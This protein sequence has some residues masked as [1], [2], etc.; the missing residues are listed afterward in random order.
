MSS[1]KIS[2]NAHNR[3]FSRLSL[4]SKDTIS[5]KYIKPRPRQ[6]DEIS[7]FNIFKAIFLI[8]FLSFIN[9]STND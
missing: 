4:Y 8:V 7:V 9:K 1:G 3:S 2:G 5:S 6:I